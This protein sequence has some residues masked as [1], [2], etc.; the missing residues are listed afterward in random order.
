MANQTAYGFI[1]L[2]DIFTQRI[3]LVN[4][5]VIQDAIRSSYEQ[6]NRQVQ[7]LLSMVRR[8]TDW[9][10]RYELAVGGTLQPLDENGNPKPIVPLG[11]Y[12]VAFPIQGAGTAWGNNRISRAQMTV[13][14]VNRMVV[15]VLTKDADW[16]IRHLLAAWY[17]NTTYSYTDPQYG[18]LTVQPLANNDSV[19]Y[20]NRAGQPTT[21]N[22]FIAQAA[23]I[24]DGTNPYPTIYDTLFARPSNSGRV[25]CM[26]PTNLKATTMALAEFRE[27]TTI[28]AA[29]GLLQ[30]ETAAAF[31]GAQTDE[32]M[33]GD[34]LL[35][36]TDSGC[37]VYEWSR[38]PNDKILAYS[39]GA[40][41][42]FA[43]R[44]YT[45]PETQGLFP[46]FVATDGNHY[47]YRSLRYAG[48]G[49]LN[50]VGALVYQVSNG[51]YSIPT[52]YS[53]PLAS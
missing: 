14:D 3:A 48:F 25:I 40:G 50:R 47:E 4:V 29:Q 23:A 16:V 8:T 49:A 34:R 45:A 42:V 32:S 21:A 28:T 5:Q 18:A 44:E 51:S 15:D 12:D 10:L 22:H 24:A 11:V 53:A 30:A 17:T 33:M 27:A 19:T 9:K 52:G 37:W 2:E 31:M 20:I 6:Q 43:M 36:V 46:E 1:D 35:G 39:E 7:A 38:L 41:E 13:Q 26:I